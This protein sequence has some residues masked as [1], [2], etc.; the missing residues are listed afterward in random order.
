MGS[1]PWQHF[2]DYQVDVN[3]ALQSL[4][5]QEFRAGRYGFA[6]WLGE[7]VS[8][9]MQ[10]NE[11]PGSGILKFG[12]RAAQAFTRPSA[13]ELIRKYGT[14]EAAIQA[15]V[16]ESEESGTKSVLDM[17]HISEI[18]DCG[19]V[20]PLKEKDL[21]SIFQTLQPNREQIEAILIREEDDVGCS[22]FWDSIANGE[23]RYII[24]Y[25]NAQPK[26]IFFAGYSFD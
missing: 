9:V 19:L 13:R 8:S 6:N 2:V 15:V 5:A 18:E 22:L 21:Q 23:G 10:A 1:T 14:V 24:A 20:C 7:M 11:T 25:E 26:E 12:F 17:S 3:E 4:K 16:D